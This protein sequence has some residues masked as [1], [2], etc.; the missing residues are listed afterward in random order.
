MDHQSPS[1]EVQ[2]IGEE[3]KKID[4]SD[5]TFSVPQR[6]KVLREMQLQKLQKVAQLPGMESYEA[7]DRDRLPKAYHTFQPFVNQSV[8]LESSKSKDIMVTWSAPIKI[9]LVFLPDTLL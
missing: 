6:K 5:T 9:K 1:M 7:I 8:S 3:F 4:S 2:L